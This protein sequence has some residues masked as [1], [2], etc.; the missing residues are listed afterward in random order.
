VRIA[1]SVARAAGAARRRRQAPPASIP[2][3]QRRAVW[4]VCPPAH[5][6]CRRHSA[7]KL[8]THSGATTRF[9]SL[10]LARESLEGPRPHQWKRVGRHDPLPLRRRWLLSESILG[11]AEAQLRHP[12]R[13]RPDAKLSPAGSNT[14]PARQRAAR[15]EH[16]LGEGLGR[17]AAAGPRYRRG[18]IAMAVDGSAR[19][20]LRTCR[21]IANPDAFRRFSRRYPCRS[22]A[23]AADPGPP[24]AGEAADFCIRKTLLSSF[25]RGGTRFHSPKRTQTFAPDSRHFATWECLMPPPSFETKEARV[26]GS[27]RPTNAMPVQCRKGLQAGGGFV[28]R[29]GRRLSADHSGAERSG[30]GPGPIQVRPLPVESAV[31]PLPNQAR[32]PGP[33]Q[34]PPRN[35]QTP[36][37]A[38]TELRGPSRARQFKSTVR[39]WRASPREA[40]DRTD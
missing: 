36:P 24:R 2:L 10:S 20:L 30:P 26:R 12:R 28:G 13:R 25:L 33:G 1:R 3:A 40:F 4:L 7:A 17:R 16:R 5:R 35:R 8:A 14:S 18:I 22:N 32:P 38:S 21:R 6:A 37:P 9:H 11:S 34:R 23:R 27:R 29:I 31:G 19:G 15:C 39:R